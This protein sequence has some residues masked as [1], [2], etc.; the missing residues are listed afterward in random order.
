M[1]ACADGCVPHAWCG[2]LLK[3][4][5]VCGASRGCCGGFSRSRMPA[6]PRTAGR[7]NSRLG[8]RNVGLRR[9]VRAA[10]IATVLHP[11]VHPPGRN[12]AHDLRPFRRR[13]AR[14]ECFRRGA[15][16][17]GLQRHERG[18]TAQRHL[19]RPGD[20]RNQDRRGGRRVR[21]RGLR[22]G[23]VRGLDGGCGEAV[24]RRARGG[25]K[26]QGDESE[27]VPRTARA[28]RTVWHGAFCG[29]DR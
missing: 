26:D 19:A 11:R 1:S 2:A 8:Q 18:R 23:R 14:G 15:R 9:R 3:P 28:G 12:P 13:S 16:G 24:G 22:A 4:R 21:H 27:R 7:M 25:R 10:C 6:F 20:A 5:A 29:G 17:R